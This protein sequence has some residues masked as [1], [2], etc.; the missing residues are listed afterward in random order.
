[1]K[2]FSRRSI[3]LVIGLCLGWYAAGVWGPDAFGPEAGFADE[4][5]DHDHLV[6]PADGD[7]NATDGAKQEP[8]HHKTGGD[9]HHGAADNLVPHE[10]DVPFYGSVLFWTAGLFVAAIVVG[11]FLRMLGEQDPS[12]GQTKIGSQVDIGH[13]R[14]THEHLD[15]SRTVIEYLR[16]FTLHQLEQEARDLAGAFLFAGDDQDKQLG[17]LSGGERS[18]AVLA[19]LVTGGHNL[20][21]LD[22]PTN[23][24]DIPS[25]E[26]LEEA[27]RRFCEPAARYGQNRN[28]EGTLLIISHD[29]M[30][31]DN[32]ASQLLIFDGLGLAGHAVDDGTPLW[33]FPW[34]NDPK[35]NVAQP[36]VL[37]KD[38]VFIGSGYATGAAR[39]ALSRDG[40]D[41]ADFGS[42]SSPSLQAATASI[43]SCLPP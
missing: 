37:G 15:M 22:E 10:G 27:L 14:Q 16:P 7:K 36:I 40:D 2:R 42:G 30:L 38:A 11:V 19:G 25:A 35:V 18:R 43:P 32:L 29:R 8:G 33:R 23:H 41:W 1:M 21:V 13:Y 24:L 20:L 4:G 12:G 5:G 9:H 6:A 39:I 28:P 3:G 17:L 31:L 34:T 26:R